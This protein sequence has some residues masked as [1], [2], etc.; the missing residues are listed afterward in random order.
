MASEQER[1]ELLNK[2]FDS[3]QQTLQKLQQE[4][5]AL[6]GKKEPTIVKTRE[7]NF[8][9]EQPNDTDLIKIMKKQVQKLGFKFANFTQVPMDYYSHTLEE[10][11]EMLQTESIHQLCK[12]LILHN[13]KCTMED[14][15][16][17]RN[18][19][20]YCVI[21]QYSAKFNSKKLLKYVREL[22]QG[23]L[24]KRQFVFSLTDAGTAFELTGFDYNG[25]SP[26]PLPSKE[27]YQIP[28]VLDK[29]IADEHKQFWIGGGTEDW[30]I[31]F[32]TDEFI[33]VF[34]PFVTDITYAA[35]EEET[36]DE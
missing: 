1:I 2:R 13:S 17:R 5:N 29:K 35:G 26:V 27:H 22:N 12:S 11:R 24:G 20:F 6:S 9:S 32:N 7:S 28:I 16:D 14:C 34:N 31:L 30:K 18:S 3:M 33:R 21:V 10:R 8:D 36:S 25:V 19:K 23:K 4:V 15:S